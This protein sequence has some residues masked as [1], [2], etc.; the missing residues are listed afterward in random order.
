VR[1][2]FRPF[3]GWSLPVGG[4]YLFIWSAVGREEMVNLADQVRVSC[5]CCPR[6]RHTDRS[7]QLA[8]AQQAA[9]ARSTAAA[10]DP[11]RTWTDKLQHQLDASG[12]AYIRPSAGRAKTARRGI[13]GIARRVTQIGRPAPRS[14]TSV[15]ADRHGPSDHDASPEARTCSK[16]RERPNLSARLRVIRNPLLRPRLERPA[17]W[18]AR[19][20]SFRTAIRMRRL[21]QHDT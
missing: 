16:H 9:G 21:P 19:W 17:L 10:A 3:P 1:R 8:S 14:A 2:S 12:S 20:L 5:F 18:R 13:R 11:L 4:V 15:S 7:R 6:Y